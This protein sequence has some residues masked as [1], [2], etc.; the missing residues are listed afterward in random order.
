M[1]NHFMLDG[2][3]EYQQHSKSGV[4][5]FGWVDGGKI[6]MAVLLVLLII[7]INSGDVRYLLFSV[8]CFS[9]KPEECQIN[10][11]HT[12]II[13]NKNLEIMLSKT[14]S[15]PFA[16]SPYVFCQRLA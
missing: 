16:G 11:L 10:T 13:M 15:Y 8:G 5:E 9:W 7:F 3:A 6:K 14:S 12:S 4:L 1:T 2:A